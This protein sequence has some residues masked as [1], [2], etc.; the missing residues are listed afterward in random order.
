M[1]LFTF[2]VVLFSCGVV[3]FSLRGGPVYL[4]GWSC[5]LVGVVLLDMVMAS[6]CGDDG[7]AADDDCDADYRN[8]D[9][10]GGDDGDGA[11][12]DGDKMSMVIL[13]SMVPVR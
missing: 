2:G 10:A 12:D 4:L 5:L 8:A 1:V 11:E 9:G 7:D 3:L 13:T 6:D